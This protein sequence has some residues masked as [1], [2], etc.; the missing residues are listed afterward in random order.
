MFSN[1]IKVF[2]ELNMSGISGFSFWAIEPIHKDG[3]GGKLRKPYFSGKRISEML[4]KE[5]EL[6]LK[7]MKVTWYNGLFGSFLEFGFLK[8]FKWHIKVEFLRNWHRKFKVFKILKISGGSVFLFRA[9]KLKFMW[10]ISWKILVYFVLGQV[11]P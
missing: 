3:N 1:K 2:K 8:S 4:L 10:Q 7:T 9:I 5:S 6:I 11:N